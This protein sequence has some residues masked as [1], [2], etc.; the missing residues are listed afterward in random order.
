MVVVMA[1][2]KVSDYTEGTSNSATGKI[3]M[4]ALDCTTAVKYSDKILKNCCF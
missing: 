3:A 2:A 4:A 1:I